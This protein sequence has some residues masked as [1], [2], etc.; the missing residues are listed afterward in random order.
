MNTS[1]RKKT[2]KFKNWQCCLKWTQRKASTFYSLPL[3]Y[4]WG[5]AAVFNILHFIYVLESFYFFLTRF[6][7]SIHIRMKLPSI[8]N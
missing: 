3:A 2:N 8:K 4:V 6:L 7:W 5:R 1:L